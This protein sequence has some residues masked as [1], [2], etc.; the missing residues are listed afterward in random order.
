MNLMG[1]KNKQEKQSLFFSKK[2]QFEIPEAQFVLKILKP[3][4]KLEV[5]T[6]NDNP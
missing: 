6:E 3:G 5:A 2:K 4:P 1:T